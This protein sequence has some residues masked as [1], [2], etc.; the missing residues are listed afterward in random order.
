[1]YNSNNENIYHPKFVWYAERNSLADIN[2]KSY[3]LIVFKEVPLFAILMRN[4]YSLAYTQTFPP[5]L[6]LICEYNS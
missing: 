1:M 2:S 4:I 6:L 5:E 3:H